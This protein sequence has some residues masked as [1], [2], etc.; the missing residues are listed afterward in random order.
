M[1]GMGIS[2]TVDVSAIAD[3]L[4]IAPRSVQRMA[5]RAGWSLETGKGKGGSKMLFRVDRLPQDVREKVVLRLAAQT[6]AQSKGEPAEP[7]PRRR[8]A[9]GASI[10]ADPSQLWEVYDKKS[11]RAKRSAE[12]RLAAI[13]AAL[14]LIGHGMPKVRAWKT[15]AERHGLGVSALR[16]WHKRVRDLPQDHW[17]PAL[18]TA[19][20]GRQ[21]VAECSPEAWEA[22]K[23]DY[24]RQEAPASA[25]CFERLQRLAGEHGW[26]IPTCDK[27][28][29]RRLH[30]EVGKA[31][32]TLARE[33]AEELA[34]RYPSQV[35]E[36]GVF[37]ALDG[38]NADGHKFDVFVRWPDGEIGRPMM[39][40]WQ[41]LGTGKLLSYRVDKTEN[42]DSVRLAFGDMIDRWGIPYNVWLDNGRAF[43]SKWLTGGTPNR[44]RFKILPEDPE[45]TITKL[46]GAENIHW[47][48]PY[49]GQ[50]KPIERAFRDLAEYV[51]R[52]PK[53]SGAYTGNKPNAKPENYGKKAIPIADFLAVLDAEIQAHNARKGRRTEACGGE[54]SYDDAWAKSYAE[55]PIRKAV[56]AQRRLFLLA[57]EGVKT[58]RETGAISLGADNRNRYWA[59]ALTNH[60]GRRLI[61]RFDPDALHQPVYVYNLDNRF[62]CEAG[63]ILA[64]GFNDTQ[65]AREHA[66]A[67][68]QFKRAQRERLEASRRMSAAD[69]AALHDALPEPEEQ[70]DP[71]ARVVRLYQP[72]TAG[73]LALD[74]HRDEDE[75]ADHF[76]AAMRL[77]REARSAED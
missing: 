37:Q 63:C 7:E 1:S 20:A 56:A 61:V 19:H 3:A 14:A 73:A 30:R 18:C 12:N 45:G 42:S 62:I 6:A 76:G 72:K 39:V 57:A 43:A 38:V 10:T 28:L 36:R 5:A 29:M 58:H 8:T 75:S 40:C 71:E 4:G 74:E 68:N 35:R 51:A 9:R 33:G 46:V 67:R 49:H 27:T 53:F 66:R 31:A 52:H 64:A 25:A 60:A 70:P 47:T 24:L 32:I 2:A 26:I 34:R 77:L 11:E 50:A 22:F 55:A 23:G 16:E 69:V 41:D 59:E 65:A 21:A 44:Y 54:L 17:L 48:T 15:A 13:G